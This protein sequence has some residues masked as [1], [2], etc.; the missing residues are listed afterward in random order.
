MGINEPTEPELQ[1]DVDFSG[2]KGKNVELYKVNERHERVADLE[3]LAGKVVSIGLHQPVL[4]DDFNP[5][6]HK[7]PDGTLYTAKTSNVIRFEMHGRTMFVR[8]KA[9][10]YEVNVVTH[11]VFRSPRKAAGEAPKAEGTTPEE[12]AEKSAR[13]LWRGITGQE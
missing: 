6:N 2:L 13:D 7:A 10:L 3:P 11:M 12:I 4:I 5:E 1:I 8:T 9:S